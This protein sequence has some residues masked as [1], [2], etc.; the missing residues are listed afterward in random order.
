MSRTATRPA[1]TRGT[2]RAV[3][4][5]VA[6]LALAVALGRGGGDDEP[7]GD[8]TSARVPQQY[9]ALFV[10]AVARYDDVSASSLAAQARVESNFDPRARSGAGAIGLMQFLPSTWEDY[11]VDGDGDG[12]IDV[13]SSADAVH[14]AARYRQV[15]HDQVGS[16]PG[17]DERHALAAYN[18]GP[19]AV[20]RYGGIP[21]YEE[22]RNYVTLVQGWAERYAYLDDMSA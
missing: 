19:G 18:A 22:T 17:S 13:R 16:L 14:T 9:E 11:G 15:L 2:P 1:S 6:V 8:T 3:L 12:N 4:V 7:G 5:V 10:E 21:P 20:L